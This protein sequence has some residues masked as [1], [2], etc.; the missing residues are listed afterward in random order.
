[1]S[2]TLTLEGNSS[3]LQAS[4]MPPIVLVG[5]WTI[6][7]VDFHT[8]NSIPNVD[9][10]N[11]VIV[12]GD[13]PVQIPEGTYELEEINETVNSILRNRQKDKSSKVNFI[14]IRG[15]NNTLKCEIESPFEVDLSL[16]NSIAPLLG[17]EPRVLPPLRKHVSSRP[18]DIVQ[19]DDIRIECSIAAGSFDNGRSSHIIYGFY[20]DVSP[21]YKL[22]QRPATII[23][24]PVTT[25]IVSEVKIRIVDQKNRPINFRGEHITVR[26]HLRQT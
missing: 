6:G 15:N 17:F 14:N 18:V 4:Y 1:M 23:Y 16:P 8:Y 26:L 19:V 22:V 7:L 21:G 11:N 2:L 12:V 20:P 3:L 25:N 5:D 10:T 13:H 24:Y 9:E